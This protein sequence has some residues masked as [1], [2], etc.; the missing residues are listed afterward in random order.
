MYSTKL[1]AAISA[2]SASHSLLS[3]VLLLPTAFLVESKHLQAY[4]HTYT[5]VTT[6]MDRICP[7]S[8]LQM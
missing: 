1:A 6:G 2:Q 4:L 5:T 3:E 7:M 8:L